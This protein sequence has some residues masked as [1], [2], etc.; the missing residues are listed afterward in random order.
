MDLLFDYLRLCK[1][2][3]LDT[4][5][6]QS[7]RTR[8]SYELTHRHRE[9]ELGQSRSRRTSIDLYLYVHSP[10]FVCRVGMQLTRLLRR[11]YSSS[12]AFRM[13]SSGNEAFF[14]LHTLSVASRLLWIMNFNATFVTFCRKVLAIMNLKTRNYIWEKNICSDR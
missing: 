1:S 12:F 9:Y 8:V 10:P 6:D 4:T 7:F 3:F 14:C 13:T 2:G 5:V 11:C